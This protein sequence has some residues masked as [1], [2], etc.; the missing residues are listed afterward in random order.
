MNLLKYVGTFQIFFE[1]FLRNTQLIFFVHDIQ[2]RVLHIFENQNTRLESSS[3]L[4]ISF[5]L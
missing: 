4:D 3:R 2:E 1:T 5:E